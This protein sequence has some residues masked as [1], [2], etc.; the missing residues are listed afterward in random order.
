[1]ESWNTKQLEAIELLAKGGENNSKVAEAVGVCANTITN[2]KN[3]PN[4]MDA[5]IDRSRELLKGR[6]TNIYD[7]L[8]KKAEEGSYQ[9]IKILLEHLDNLDKHRALCSASTITF[10]WNLASEHQN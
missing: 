6:L 10:M 8:A 7:A 3:N 9:H 2:W 1:M 5:V 4:F